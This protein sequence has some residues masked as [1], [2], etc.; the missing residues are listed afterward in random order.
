VH[1]PPSVD[2]AA[3][4]A[5]LSEHVD[6]QI[7]KIQATISTQLEGPIMHGVARL[8]ESELLNCDPYVAAL[9]KHFEELDHSKFP[10]VEA[11]WKPKTDRRLD[12]HDRLRKEAD[13]IAYEN[14]SACAYTKGHIK[15]QGNSIDSLQS[16]VD[17]QER[18]VEKLTNT[19]EATLKKI[20]HLEQE[21]KRPSV[22]EFDK[23]MDDKISE[24]SSIIEEKI[25]LIV[26]SQ[27]LT[28]GISYVN[29]LTG[30][31]NNKTLTAH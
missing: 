14:S 24:L 22:V 19:L 21:Q 25:K 1:Q 31:I 2:V 10:L 17:M 9:H 18:K 4:E 11:S 20:E 3:L 26:T 13:A 28:A 7:A 12:E 27:E 29:G 6:A 8:V 23:T 15:E 5:K 16:E 30:N